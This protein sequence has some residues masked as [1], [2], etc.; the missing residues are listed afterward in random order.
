[1]REV[2][3]APQV[4]MMEGKEGKEGKSMSEINV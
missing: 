4:M 2:K 3:T 1:M